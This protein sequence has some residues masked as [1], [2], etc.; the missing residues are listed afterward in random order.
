MKLLNTLTNNNANIVSGTDVGNPFLVAG[1]SLHDELSIMQ[2]AGLTPYQVLLS[3]TKNCAEMLGY[4]SRLGTIERNKDADLVLLK[5]NP[6]ENINNT[7]SIVGVMT[8]GSWYP[9]EE[10]NSMLDDIAAKKKS[11]MQKL[12]I[13]NNV[14]L[15]LLVIILSLTFLS[16]I[17]LRPVLYFFNR[18]KL[19]SL[20]RDNAHIKK[21]RIRFFVTSLS[22]M[23]LII[24]FLIATLPEVVIQSGLPTSLVGVS[25][26][27]RYQV[28]LPFVNLIF[29]IS[30]SIFYVVG[31]LK[32]DFST[33]RKWY[34][35]LIII[36]SI[37]TFILINYWGF[38]KL[39]IL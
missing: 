33:Y 26:L 14:F 8:K 1:F 37:I 11:L 38:M 17:L 10:L 35:F 23:S 4:E 7:K 3:A 36:T 5:N 9:G 18:N 21:Y 28:L 20:I 15:M 24:L 12:T 39:Y 22:I 13:R 2:D 31:I 25:A 32:G 34:T 16:A 29:L 19:K 30:L 27:V 6:L